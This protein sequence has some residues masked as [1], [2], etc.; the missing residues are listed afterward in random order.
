MLLFYSPL[1]GLV[2]SVL[3][4]I[5]IDQR[6]NSNT[7]KLETASMYSLANRL[8]LF[9][10]GRTECTESRLEELTSAKPFGF[11]CVI[12][13]LHE[14]RGPDQTGELNRL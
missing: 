12:R 6:S 9:E 1:H 13:F 7:S 4:V 3:S 8:G 2:F 10:Q 5:G 14:T 11:A